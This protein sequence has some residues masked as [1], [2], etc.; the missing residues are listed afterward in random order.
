MLNMFLFFG[1][2]VY[3]SK[4]YIFAEKAD[5]T[6]LL[7]DWTV[8][9]TEQVVWEGIL[10]LQD[11]IVNTIETQKASVVNIIISK[12]LQF[13]MQ[14]P[15]GYFGQ[16]RI[17]ER[18]AQ[19]W[20]GSW[21]II[22]KDGYIMTNKHVVSDIEADYTVVDSEWTLFEVVNIRRDPVIDI[23]ILQIVV[24]NN[25]SLQAAKFIEFDQE[26]KIGQFVIAVGNALA[27][28]QNSVTLGILS[29]KNRMLDSNWQESLYIGLYQTDTSINPGNSWGPLFDIY[30]Q[31][32]WINTAVRSDSDGIWFALPVTQWFVR[33][34]LETIN[35]NNKINRPFMWIQYVDLSKK[36]SSELWLNPIEGTYIEWVLDWSPAARAWIQKGDIITS[37]EWLPI[38]WDL[39]LLYHIYQYSIWDEIV[40]TI[41]R[42]WKTYKNS[43]ILENN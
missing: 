13:F 23:A 16:G 9:A 25:E 8:N 10:T 39:P 41:D 37:I 24:D 26:V 32:I 20:G 36:V 43:M 3:L 27:E 31:V 12:N 33:A 11:Q 1:V 7:G 2:Q 30:W 15:N 21:I 14:D 35:E 18:T 5:L 17:A 6:A 40:L 38:K 34:T 19:I 4:Q 22:A 42:N 28:Y 29:A